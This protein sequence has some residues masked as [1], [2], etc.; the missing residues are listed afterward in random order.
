[1]PTEPPMWSE[2]ALLCKQMCASWSSYCLQMS[3]ARGGLGAARGGSLACRDDRAGCVEC[4]GGGDTMSLC[5]GLAPGAGNC[6]ISIASICFCWIC[7]CSICCNIWSR[8]T[9]WLGPV[10]SPR[11]GAALSVLWPGAGRM[12]AAAA[13]CSVGSPLD[14][15][16]TGTRFESP[17]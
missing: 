14:G 10:A 2:G 12:A 15:A 13:G 11:A 4:R 1:M 6:C 3:G 17:F 8:S 16:A 9:G 5:P 7:C